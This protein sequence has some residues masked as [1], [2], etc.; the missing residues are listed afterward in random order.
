[1]TI[2][3]KMYFWKLG[4]DAY[5][6]DLAKNLKDFVGGKGDNLLILSP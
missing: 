2:Q 3:S 1:M 4:T 6:W 5:N